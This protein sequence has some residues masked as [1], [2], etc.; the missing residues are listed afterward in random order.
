M[1]LDTLH[2]HKAAH[3]RKALPEKKISAHNAKMQQ[4]NLDRG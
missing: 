4:L 1:S 2:L 3:K